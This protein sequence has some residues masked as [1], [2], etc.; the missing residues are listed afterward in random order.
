MTP[1]QRSLKKLRDEGWHCAI[2]EKW[3]S[4]TKTRH[5]LFGCIDILAVRGEHTLGVQ[6]TSASNVGARVRKFAESE[7]VPKLRDAGWILKIWGWRK[8]KD[9]KWVCRE[10][11][12]S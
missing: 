12:V 2:V 11:D 7:D 9:G 5:D 6:T 4:F 10:V 8:G 3:N 1:T